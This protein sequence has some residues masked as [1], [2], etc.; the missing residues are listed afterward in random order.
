MLRYRWAIKDYYDAKTD[1]SVRS[2]QFRVFN[3][4]GDFLVG[5]R[6]DVGIR[7]E[8]N[9]RNVIGDIIK[10]QEAAAESFKIET[11]DPDEFERALPKVLPEQRDAVEKQ[12]SDYMNFAEDVKNSYL[13]S[14]H[15]KIAYDRILRGMEQLSVWQAVGEALGKNQEHLS[16]TEKLKRKWNAP[17]EKQKKDVFYDF[18]RISDEQKKELSTF[19]DL[20]EKIPE[21]KRKAVYESYVFAKHL[22]IDLS[23]G[24]S[25]RI[26]DKY[27]GISDAEIRLQFSK[28][29]CPEYVFSGRDA[30][31]LIRN[32]LKVADKRDDYNAKTA[33]VCEQIKSKKGA[34]EDTRAVI[35]ETERNQELLRLGFIADVIVTKN[36]KVDSDLL[37]K[38]VQTFGMT[39]YDIREKSRNKT[40]EFQEKSS[41]G[42]QLLKELFI[43]D[44]L[45]DRLRFEQYKKTENTAFLASV[46]EVEK[47]KIMSVPEVLGAYGSTMMSSYRS[48]A[49]VMEALKREAKEGKDLGASLKLLKRLVSSSSQFESL[50]QPGGI[51]Q[52]M[53]DSFKNICKESLNKFSPNRDA[54]IDFANALKGRDKK[55][56]MQIDNFVQGVSEAMNAVD[57]SKR[58]KVLED[59]LKKRAKELEQEG[60]VLS[61]VQVLTATNEEIKK[62]AD[63]GYELKDRDK[64]LQR[65]R[66]V[67]KPL[68]EAQENLVRWSR[69]K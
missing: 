3:N 28:G 7:D 15:Y 66:K 51:K 43:A 42:Y 16:F 54:Y 52:Y 26:K 11:N 37:R 69:N 46:K 17:T 67:K 50:F 59:R 34:A 9:Q 36:P 4:K 35:A 62:R 60:N 68:T 24:L 44:A 40:N 65:M 8:T 41:E 31:P 55:L 57:V 30:V 21:K 32:F 63:E 10:K 18:S 39:E 61:G 19:Y 27:S 22:F 53:F 48:A 13:Q 45:E 29:G 64:V 25:H 1:N 20:V 6:E 2:F 47:A 14:M 12:L 49:F 33:A 38:F 23:A 56:S 5:N 58:K